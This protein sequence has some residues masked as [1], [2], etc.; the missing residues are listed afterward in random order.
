MKLSI[1]PLSSNSRRAAMV[2]HHLGLP[3]EMAIVDLAKGEQRSPAHLA[4]HPGGK[5]PV[6]QDGDFVLTESWAIML[7]LVEKTP[8]PLYP[9]ALH[10][11]AHI[12]EWMFWAASHWSTQ[13]S[14]LNFENMIKGM[15]GAGPADPA[16][17]ALAETEVRACAKRLDAHLATHAYLVGEALTLA[18]FAVA[19]P[20]MSTVPAKLPV[21][22]YVHLQRWF[23]T[24]TEL[25]AWR[26]TE[27]TFSR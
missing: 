23:A 25:P 8:N 9:A 18:D 12:H 2:A 21:T 6:L 13:I 20:L 3:V 24:I 14:I 27:P 4:L 22:D 10:T 7:Y 5:V 15:L 17:V 19:T 16:R 26:A 11:R 1:H